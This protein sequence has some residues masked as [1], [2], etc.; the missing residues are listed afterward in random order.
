MLMLPAPWLPKSY[1]VS[2][3]SNFGHFSIMSHD[4]GAI[5]DKGRC[6]SHESDMGEQAREE[7]LSEP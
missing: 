4:H 1:P 2:H 5:M 6:V 3:K 7:V